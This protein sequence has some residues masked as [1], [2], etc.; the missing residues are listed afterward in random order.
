VKSRPQCCGRS[1][2]KDKQPPRRLLANSF[3]CAGRGVWLAFC[4]R[5][6]RL[7]LVATALVVLA[8]FRFRVSS[9]QWGQLII[10]VTLVIGAE[11]IN[12]AVEYVVDLAS[13]GYAELARM[14]KDA[15]AGAVLVTA[16]AALALGNL[17]FAA[18][19]APWLRALRDALASWNPFFAA[20]LAA[21]AL[22]LEVGLWLPADRQQRRLLC[23]SLIVVPW[24]A[25]LFVAIP[26]LPLLTGI[27]VLLFAV[28]VRMGCETL[29]HFTIRLLTEAGW[30]LWL[31]QRLN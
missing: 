19:L 7:H 8:G 20:G 1:E 3:R 4:Q 30:W 27:V 11:I 24:L 6:F 26:T 18:P 12:T 25:R 15:A 9:L 16:L 10:A 14:A 13:P 5:N 31:W 28:W 2:L 21:A 23:F 22:V 29:A 17:V